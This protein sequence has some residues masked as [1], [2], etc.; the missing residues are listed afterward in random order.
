RSSDEVLAE[1]GIYD[2]AKEGELVFAPLLRRWNVFTRTDLGEAGEAARA[3][4]A[5]LRG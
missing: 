4:L 2:P 3:E 1:A 5:H